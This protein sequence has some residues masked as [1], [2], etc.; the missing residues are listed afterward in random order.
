MRTFFLKLG[1][2]LIT[3]KYTPLTPAGCHS[4]PGAGMCGRAGAG[5]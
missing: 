5:A 3:D 2:S 1:G 4:A